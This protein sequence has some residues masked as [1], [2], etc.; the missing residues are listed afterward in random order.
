MSNT[1]G[2][3]ELETLPV[4]AVNPRGQLMATKG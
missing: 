2:A 3:I 4:L 1:V